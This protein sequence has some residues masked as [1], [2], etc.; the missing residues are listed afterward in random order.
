MVNFRSVV[1]PNNIWSFDELMLPHTASHDSL[2]TFIPR[3]PHS[4][5][6]V[7][8]LAAIQLANSGLPFI[9]GIWPV[10]SEFGLSGPHAFQTFLNEVGGSL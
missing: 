4:L 5:G 2:V 10:T 8:Y 1:C 9:M 6:I 3:K 7:T